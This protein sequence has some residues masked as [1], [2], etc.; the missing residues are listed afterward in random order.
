MFAVVP[1]ILKVSSGIKKIAVNFVFIWSVTA[2]KMVRDVMDDRKRALVLGKFKFL[3]QS[4]AE[5]LET[6]DKFNLAV[7]QVNYKTYLNKCPCG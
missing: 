7:V 6:L 1:L 2:V 3:Y 4:D 5:E